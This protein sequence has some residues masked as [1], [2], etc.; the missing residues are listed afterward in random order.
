LQLDVEPGT[1]VPVPLQSPAFVS[2]PFEHD[3]I[4]HTVLELHSSHAPAPLQNPSVPHVACA[5][6]AHSASGSEPAAIGPQV[7]SAPEP[8]LAAVHAWHNPLHV[9]LQHTLSTQW[10]FAHS[11]SPT[12]DVPSGFRPTHWFEPLQKFP[13]AQ[14]FGPVQ[15]V[16]HAVPPALHL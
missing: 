7:P 1:H 14:S 8:F 13:A 15:L 5:V 2:T 16:R 9:K 4:E 3:G 10:L 11:P 12:H 6:D